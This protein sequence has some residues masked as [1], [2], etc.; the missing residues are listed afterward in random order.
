MRYL[1]EKRDHG[2]CALCGVDTYELAKQFNL[3][4]K[5]WPTPP[6][7]ANFLEKHGIPLSRV[8]SDWWD[9]DHIVPVIEGGGECTLENFRTLCIPCHKKVTKELRAR[10]AK[11]DALVRADTKDAARPLFE[12]LQSANAEDL[13]TVTDA[14]EER[15]QKTKP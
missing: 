6:E 8:L 12:L 5:G 3:L 10:L 1:L 15:Q 7:R 2:I 11:A 4:P 13:Q 9:A 14:S